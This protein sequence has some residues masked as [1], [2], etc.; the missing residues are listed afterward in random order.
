MVG[1][2]LDRLDGGRNNGYLVMIHSSGEQFLKVFLPTAS[3]SNNGLSH[4]MG[5]L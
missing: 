4:V 2:G 5:A 3:F 1:D